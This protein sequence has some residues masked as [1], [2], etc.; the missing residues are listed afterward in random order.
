MKKEVAD[1][2]IAALESG[3]YAQAIG[4]LQQTEDTRLGDKVYP[5]GFC[6]L[7]VLCEVAIKNGFHVEKMS[8][9]GLKKVA[10]DGAYDY[11]P[12]TVREWAGMKSTSGEFSIEDDP[13]RDSAELI[14]LNDNGKTFKEIAQIIRDNW[15]KL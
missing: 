7:G 2:W 6:C 4:T 5:K 14:D 3:E 9:G 10:Y 8:E 12:N 11:L 15:E 13:D 1:L